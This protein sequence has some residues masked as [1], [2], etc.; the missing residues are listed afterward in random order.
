M[1]PGAAR[2]QGLLRDLIKLKNL[3]SRE[4]TKNPH[5]NAGL[6]DSKGFTWAL[7]H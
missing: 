6:L 1:T 3:N 2:F 4:L 5:V 7:F